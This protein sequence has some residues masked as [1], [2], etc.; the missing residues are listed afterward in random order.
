M[1]KWTS[2]LPDFDKVIGVVEATSFEK[3]YLW[4][5]ATESWRGNQLGETV[6]VGRLSRRPVCIS[7]TIDVIGGYP[8]LFVEATSQVVDYLMIDNWLLEN[9]PA[10]ALKRGGYLNKVD[11]MNFYNVFP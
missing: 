7:L 1:G 11:A 3:Q 5:S 4:S 8:I 6:I 2:I 10:T 9:L